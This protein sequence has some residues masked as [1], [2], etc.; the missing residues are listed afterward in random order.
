MFST[1]DVIR[2]LK[3]VV[4]ER[5][6]GYIYLPERNTEHKRKV[7]TSYSYEDCLAGCIIRNLDPKGHQLFLD[8][9]V[10]HQGAFNIQS[11]VRSATAPSY[12]WLRKRY[13]KAYDYL[14]ANFD[15]DA[16]NILIQAQNQQ[17]ARVPYGVVES[18]VN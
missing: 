5:G 10:E 18:N 12:N 13:A 16:I 9:E 6:R 1:E 3:A 11:V 4:K 14:K 2:E 17:D 15:H 8:T 7:G